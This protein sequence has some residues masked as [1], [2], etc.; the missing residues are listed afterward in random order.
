[1]KKFRCDCGS[2]S[3]HGSED[4]YYNRMAAALMDVL[5]EMR[6]DAERKRMERV[7]EEL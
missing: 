1:M 4:C 2:A 3:P 7:W 5:V 6:E